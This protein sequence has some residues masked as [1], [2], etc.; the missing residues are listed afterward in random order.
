[1]VLDLL[2]IASARLGSIKG[3][4]YILCQGNLCNFFRSAHQ[5][6]GWLARVNA[7]IQVLCSR[8]CTCP[9]LVLFGIIFDK[10]YFL[11]FLAFKPY[12]M[13]NSSTFQYLLGVFGLSL[14][15]KGPVQ[16]QFELIQN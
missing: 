1:M 14:P 15:I 16:C 9:S 13:I 12:H 11:V 7:F 6:L 5:V 10:I 3:V 8:R 4:N 2:L